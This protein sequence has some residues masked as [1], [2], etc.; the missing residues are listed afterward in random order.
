MD[1]EAPSTSRHLPFTAFEGM[2]LLALWTASVVSTAPLLSR[3]FGTAHDWMTA[4]VLLT[5]RGYEGWGF[6]TLWGAS[7]LAPAS[8]ELQHADLTAFG[9][10][11]G[12]Y[13]SY[14][15]GTYWLAYAAYQVAASC[16]FG[17]ADP[18]FVA[19]WTLLSVRLLGLIAVYLALR[20]LA[21]MAGAGSLTA[22][23]AMAGAA[24][25]LLAPEILYATQETLGPDQ[26]VLPMVSAMIWLG[27]RARFDLTRVS[28]RA[29]WAYA[30]ITGVA[31]FT[32]WYA[33]LTAAAIA[34]GFVLG[35]PGGKWHTRL[36]PWLI[37]PP[38]VAGAVFAAQL[39]HFEH[40]LGDLIWI[41]GQR[42]GALGGDRSSGDSTFTMLYMAYARVFN[43]LPPAFGLE[44][45]EFI[46][47]LDAQ[48]LPALEALAGLLALGAVVGLGLRAAL[49]RTTERH[50]L[51][52][53]LGV[54]VVLPVVQMALLSQHSYIH[55]FSAMKLAL[56]MAALVV[57]FPVAMLALGERQ[58]LRAI[59]ALALAATLVLPQVATATE[60]ARVAGGPGDITL[61][62]HGDL[63]AATIAPT[64][65]PLSDDLQIRAWPSAEW[66]GG[67]PLEVN[68]MAGRLVY[69]SEYLPYF[70]PVM[71][72]EDLARMRPVVIY[73]EVRGP[74]RYAPW[75]DPGPH[76][77]V[78][79]VGGWRVVVHAA[80][81]LRARI[82]ERKARPTPG[83][84][85]L[86]NMRY[87]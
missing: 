54:V 86:D 82:L 16:G 69:D 53:S 48:R 50:A 25:W 19:G 46:N 62:A 26:A 11:H 56:P 22:P 20:E 41:A 72:A 17:A 58:P 6:A 4:H 39:A 33:W 45:R 74:R 59:L 13:L 5:L 29:A 44:T 12:L 49:A 71:K 79:K 55:S 85:L 34:L 35:A 10:G 64:D 83:R 1:L 24:C 42:M 28:R 60:S 3:H 27:L 7:L 87:L 40:G 57:T 70:L 30:V 73:Y 15:A 65:L 63:I 32:D 76:L 84:G 37:A 61:S 67:A 81:K 23:S 31:C 9:K 43:L 36:R 78:G 8:L 52:I 75:L 68:A 38:L 80:T 77:A 18:D 47:A 21:A 2:L 66:W 14:P 51:T